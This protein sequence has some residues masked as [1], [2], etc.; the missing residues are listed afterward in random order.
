MLQTIDLGGLGGIEVRASFG[1]MIALSALDI[2]RGVFSS[3]CA[4][5]Q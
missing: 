3:S 4:D 2:N 5:Y 1:A